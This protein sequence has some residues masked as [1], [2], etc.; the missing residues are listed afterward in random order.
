MARR[1]AEASP[2][3]RARVHR[4]VTS[5][6]VRPRQD[7]H[8]GTHTHTHTGTHTHATRVRV[9][10]Y[11]AMTK[12]VHI[13]WLIIS[14]LVK[15]SRRCDFTGAPWSAALLSLVPTLPVPGSG[16]SSS[17]A[18]WYADAVSFAAWRHTGTGTDTPG[19][20]MATPWQHMHR[21][22]VLR[23]WCHGQ[24]HWWGSNAWHTPATVLAWHTGATTT[25]HCDREHDTH[26]AGS[27][28]SGAAHAYNRRAAMYRRLLCSIF[29]RAYMGEHLRRPQSRW[30]AKTTQ[31]GTF[32]RS[33]WTSDDMPSGVSSPSLEAPS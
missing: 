9:H 17:C 15:P 3:P 24:R 26:V 28:S 11:S 18:A 16:V 4:H 21:Y 22:I 1:R 20:A 30:H 10:D 6:Q 12:H 33:S 29:L 14:I 8:T 25:K 7:T 19:E 31:Q 32:C 27:R 5:P 13:P 23:W 2:P